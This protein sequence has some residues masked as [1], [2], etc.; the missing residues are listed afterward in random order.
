ML[1]KFTP[2]LEETAQRR[3][4]VHSNTWRQNIEAKSGERDWCEL[5]FVDFLKMEAEKEQKRVRTRCHFD[6]S[7]SPRSKGD[8]GAM[9]DTNEQEPH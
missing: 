8:R 9:C 2:K 7:V 4:G 5:A 1:R 3:P 6:T